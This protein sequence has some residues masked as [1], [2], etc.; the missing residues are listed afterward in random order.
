[1]GNALMSRLQDTLSVL[2]SASNYEF[3][4]LSVQW[5]DASDSRKLSFIPDFIMCDVTMQDV[6][7]YANTFMLVLNGFAHI[8]GLRIPN[9]TTTQTDRVG[10]LYCD[11]DSTVT[12]ENVSGRDQNISVCGVAI[13]L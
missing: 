1:M 7:V 12:L 3:F 8:S 5:T 11:R 10:T 4:G 13:K 6:I 9:S 2:K